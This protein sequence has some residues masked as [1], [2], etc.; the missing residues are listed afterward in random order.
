MTA[1][2]PTPAPR[3]PRAIRLCRADAAAIVTHARAGLPDEACGLLAGTGERVEVV[4]PAA[5]ADASPVS[6]RVESRDQWHAMRDAEARGLEMLGGFHSHTHSEPYPSATDVAQAFY[7][8]W[9][10][11]IVGL[12]GAEP[13]LRAFRIESGAIAEIPVLVDPE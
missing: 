4:Y 10:Y 13:V 1:D 6:Y 7:P 12:G 2:P 3:G 8:D 5:N 9:A 11:L